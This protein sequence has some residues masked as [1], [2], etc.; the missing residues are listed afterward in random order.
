MLSGVNLG[1]HFALIYTSFS[2]YRF[3]TLLIINMAAGITTRGALQAFKDRIQVE[4]IVIIPAN[5]STALLEN[6]VEYHR[7][8]VQSQ[9]RIGCALEQLALN[10]QQMQ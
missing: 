9:N 3:L 2:S 7:I 6:T 5:I 10:L 1:V 4:D 8:L